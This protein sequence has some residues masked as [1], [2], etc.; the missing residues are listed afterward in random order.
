MP[1]RLVTAADAA[2]YTGRPVGT[3]WRWASEG[4]IR[5]EG[6]GKQARYHLDDLPRATRDEWTGLLTP[7]EAPPLPD[8]ARA[9]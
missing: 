5:R 6:H 1:P 7:G 3:I 4:R 2:H 9:A 8:G